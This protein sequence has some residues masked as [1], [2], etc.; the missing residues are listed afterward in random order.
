MIAQYE[1][2]KDYTTEK[3]HRA[4]YSEPKCSETRNIRSMTTEIITLDIYETF[5]ILKRKNAIKL[6]L[7]ICSRESIV[8]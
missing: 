7:S 5:N 4:I 2:G 6:I 8:S 3:R 1:I